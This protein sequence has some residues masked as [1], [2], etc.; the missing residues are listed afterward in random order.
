MARQEVGS[1][2]HPDLASKHLLQRQS[3]VSRLAATLSPAVRRNCCAVVAPASLLAQITTASV[4]CITTY[5]DRREDVGNDLIGER[6]T[7]SRV[8]TLEWR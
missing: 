1:H 7:V 8:W 3:S 2:F 5:L 4:F 6:S